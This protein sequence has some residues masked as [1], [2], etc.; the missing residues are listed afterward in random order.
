LAQTKNGHATISYG[1]YIIVWA[2]LMALTAVTVLV[3]E[4]RLPVIGIIVAMVIAFG[5]AGFVAAYFMHLRYEVNKAYLL[6]LL[7]ALLLLGIFIGL[8]F[9][10]I[11]VRY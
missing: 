1:T 3:G 7:L 5:K 11:G 2:V 8:T 9:V 4:L 10:D 6:V